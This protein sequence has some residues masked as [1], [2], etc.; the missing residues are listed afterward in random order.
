MKI[1]LVESNIL[2]KQ[3]Y[4]LNFQMYLGMTDV[5]VVEN[6]IE[7]IDYLKNN[8]VDIVLSKH[9]IKNENSSE[10]L[11]AF[12]ND[13]VKETPLIIIG[14][15]DMFSFGASYIDSSIN[16]KKILR[17]LAG[18]L[19]VSAKDMARKKVQEYIKIPKEY[20][21]NITWINVNIHDANQQIIIEK[22]NILNY[23]DIDSQVTD[24]F[25]YIYHLDRL[26]FTEHFSNEIVSQLDD[27]QLTT[28]EQVLLGEVL[29]DE[30]SVRVSKFGISASTIEQ[31]KKMQKVVEDVCENTSLR[32]LF[33]N[34]VEQK[35][36]YRYRHML[37]SSF[38]SSHMLKQMDWGNEEQEKKMRFVSVF[39]NIY[40]TD[41]KL[42]KITSNEQLKSANLSPAEHQLVIS[43]A[44][45]AAELVQ[46]M[47]R[48]PMGVDAI[49]RQHHGSVTGMGF[50]E[51]YSGNLSP[52]SLIFIVSE[53]F[54]HMILDEESQF[55]FNKALVQIKEK[56]PTKRFE[57]IIKAIAEVK[58]I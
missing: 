17:V 9:I 30:I 10:I 7:A 53:Q 23:E 1:L 18:I 21:K 32:K 14:K 58:R 35:S 43:H 46:Q 38:I 34:L 6:A 54:T 49:I 12:M 52:L 26:Q 36:S 42:V 55:N 24:E 19:N 33:D 2:Y 29:T 25:I 44:N 39:Q 28:K 5:I 3:L 45:K 51:F 15:R 20:L 48:I 31:C 47:G 56:F 22:D 13:E 8:K 11:E 41:D 4:C 57:K 40:L 16:L 27:C 37:V 50:S